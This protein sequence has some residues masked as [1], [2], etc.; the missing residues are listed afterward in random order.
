MEDETSEMAD[1]GWRVG[2]LFR[3]LLDEYV[4]FLWE[5][6]CFSEPLLPDA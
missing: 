2:L 5:P 1:H 4:H 3:C 6:P